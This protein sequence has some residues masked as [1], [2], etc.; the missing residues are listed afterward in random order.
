MDG[1]SSFQS[2]RKAV[3]ADVVDVL[4]NWDLQENIT[5]LN[6]LS[7]DQTVVFQNIFCGINKWY[8]NQFVYDQ[9]LSNLDVFRPTFDKDGRI[10]HMLATT[11]YIVDPSS[12]TIQ[13]DGP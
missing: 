3:D 13:P 5:R 8:V 12:E 11:M 2:K 9:R 6:M 1:T 7:N 10:Y 4:Q